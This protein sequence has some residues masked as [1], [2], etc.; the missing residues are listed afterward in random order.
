MAVNS[1]DMAQAEEEKMKILN[2]L[3]KNKKLF[4]LK[5]SLEC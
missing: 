2:K 3:L 1:G 5:S 4:F